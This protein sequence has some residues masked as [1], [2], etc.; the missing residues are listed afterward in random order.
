MK[1][2]IDL[3]GMRAFV[4]VAE[5]KSF[6]A[7]ANKLG[8]S[9]S[10][11]SRRLDAYEHALG[12]TL[13]RRSTRSISL[14]DLGAQHFEKTKELIAEAEAAIGDIVGLNNEPSGL[15][16]L[17]GS[18]AGGQRLLLPFVWKFM[19][20]Y[21]KVRVELVLTDK[22]VDVIDDGIDFA[23]RMGDLADSE[24]LVR[25]MGKGKRI[26]VASPELISQY[27]KPKEIKDLKKLPAIVTASNQHI[28]RFASGESVSVNWKMCAGAIPVAVEGALRGIGMSLVPWTY[29]QQYL[30]NGRLVEVLP[31][32]PLPA[33]DISL[34]YPR[35]R[36]QS[37][38][39]KAFL[40]ETKNTNI[41]TPG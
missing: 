32:E 27:T 4:A 15:I 2:N 38:A 14:T 8:S 1:Q 10:T 16:R 7:A 26:I 31:N 37:P 6:T 20:K 34:V 24:L 12:A 41:Q 25:R 28:W 18:Y 9:K 22:I 39:A 36:H 17:S 21:P 29:C 5:T 40:Q 11:I 19:E 13:F 30:A 35:L 3:E 23:L 33:V